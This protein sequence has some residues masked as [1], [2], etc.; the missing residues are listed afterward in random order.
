M[1][2]PSDKD[3][4]LEP[5]LTDPS[6]RA[7]V[8]ALTQRLLSFAE[9]TSKDEDNHRYFFARG[10]EFAT[11]FADHG[12]AMVDVRGPRPG[13]QREGG[14]GLR[15]RMHQG[16]H[17]EGWVLVPLD[18]EDDI[19]AAEKMAALAYEEVL[20]AAP[21]IAVRTE[22]PLESF[23]GAAPGR[24]KPAKTKPAKAAPKA[25]SGKRR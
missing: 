18:G 25:K 24:E 11:I 5:R 15:E 22:R 23:V 10:H 13:S 7:R 21:T 16:A 12:K 19:R 9:T 6:A 2:R 8:E 1:K 20:G 4:E 3:E 14:T 17:R